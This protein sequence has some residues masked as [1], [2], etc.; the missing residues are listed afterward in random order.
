M[1][2]T[3]IVHIGQ[4]EV[5]PHIAICLGSECEDGTYTDSTL[6][7]IGWLIFDLCIEIPRMEE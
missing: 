2:F 4:F 5:F 7:Y 3:K 1:R 6:V